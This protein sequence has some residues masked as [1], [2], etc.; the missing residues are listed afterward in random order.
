M[1][2]RNRVASVSSETVRDWF[3]SA[4][5][6]T[7]EEIDKAFA[8]LLPGVKKLV[9]INDHE[10]RMEFTFPLE[11]DDLLRNVNMTIYRH[12]RSLGDPDVTAQMTTCDGITFDDRALLR[13]VE[14]G[15]PLQTR[16]KKAVEGEVLFD[17][18]VVGSY[19]FNPPDVEK[20][21]CKVER[22]WRDREFE[23]GVAFN[24]ETGEQL[25]KRRGSKHSVK[26][27]MYG[28]E[29]HVRTHYHPS[30]QTFSPQD[31]NTACSSGFGEERVVDDRYL[32]VFR[33]P[34]DRNPGKIY[35]D[36]H[37]SFH[38]WSNELYEG[39]N[40][41]EMAPEE[42][43][44][45]W[46]RI[47]PEIGVHYQRIPRDCVYEGVPTHK[48]DAVEPFTERRR[49]W[50]KKELGGEWVGWD[51]V[52]DKCQR[53]EEL[54]GVSWC[55][56]LKGTRFYASPCI[57]DSSVETWERPV[58]G[59][60]KRLFLDNTTPGKDEKRELFELCE[61]IGFRRGVELAHNLEEQGLITMHARGESRGKSLMEECRGY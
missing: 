60:E 7:P 24:S 14:E 46:E 53:Y 57:E 13:H 8:N 44:A 49:I 20:A 52:R 39:K 11:R 15:E 23:V 10:Y 17:G 61:N 38:R 42:R 25:Y 30:I 29:G 33:I 37:I 22:T 2:T 6:L 48:V 50:L 5:S 59:E 28:F 34:P 56:E 32:Y 58:T 4:G 12:I 21:I 18:R 43:N 35:Q 54:T 36:W 51:W 31:L 27:P 45:V 1:G 26:W 47:A 40:Y 55:I 41:I 16:P 3:P 9:K 19:P